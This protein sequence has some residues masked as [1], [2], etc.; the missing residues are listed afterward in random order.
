M[1]FEVKVGPPQLSIHQGYVVLVS[2][3]DGQINWP[4]EK[5][6]YCLDTRVISSWAVYANGESWD[7][8]NGGTTH[9]FSSR[10]FLTNREIATQSGPIAA[11][12]LGLAISR[13]ICGGMHEDLELVNYGNQTVCF[14]LEV[15]LRSDFADIFEV[16]S[17]HSVRRGRITTEWSSS[18]QRL[19]TAYRNQ[20]F[21]REVAVT[22]EGNDTAALY[23]NGRITFEVVLPPGATWHTCLI[24]DLSDG[25]R[26]YPGSHSCNKVGHDD[27]ENLRSLREWHKAVLKVESTNNNVTQI[28]NQAT[29]DL[30]ALRLEVEANDV[31]HVVPAAGL[32][33]FMALFGR[34]SLIVSIQTAVAYPEFA[35]GSLEVLGMHQA[36]E[37]DDF[38]DAEP[39]KIMHELRLGEL[40]KLKLV[41]HTPYYGTAD[42]TPLYLITLHTAWCATGDREL[43]MRHMPVAERCLEWIDHYGDR[44][45]DGF[46]E[47]GTRSSSGLENQGWKD[48][49]DGMVYLDGT[50]MRGPKALCELQGYVYDGW[51]RMAKLYDVLGNSARAAELRAKAAALYKHFNEIFWD[52]AAGFYALALDGRKQK[53][54]SI[55]SNA[56]HL[57]WSGIVPPERARRVVERLMQP[58]MWSGWGIRTLSS[59]HVSYN[60]YSY[61]KGSVWPHD[62]GLIA[63]GFKRYGYD[64]EAG[65]IATGIYEAGRF[66]AQYQYPELYA[67]LQREGVTF[68]VQYLGANVPQAWAAGSVFSMLQAVL[69]LQPDAANRRLFV[70]PEL[71]PR[72]NDLTVRDLRVGDQIFDI[73]FTRSGDTTDFEVLRGDPA[74][75]VRRNV[76]TWGDQLKCDEQA[77]A[78]A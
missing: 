77:Q 17:G 48:S 20:D 4:S 65:L 49:G 74:A 10:I 39:G 16:K 28:F 27:S 35:R 53:V 41:P 22:A 50:L 45:G 64:R 13:E 75:V 23:A 36:T 7:L 42:A 12:T 18:G 25:E 2:E 72:L 34:D 29:D 19:T 15:A 37:R 24:Y 1:S 6:L 78:A 14:N 68:P 47:Y 46:Q 33:W 73:R 76:T 51:L 30:A 57:L 66:F 26:C 31:T 55:A 5:G 71:P 60:P 43:L 70:D 11:H 63:Q 69:G 59:N 3:L 21:F 67:G 9:S 58:D 62:N 32:P 38:R 56:G 52:E 40:A 44:D 54:M 8:L 61:Q